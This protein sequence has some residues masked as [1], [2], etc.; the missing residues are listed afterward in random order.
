M[1]AVRILAIPPQPIPYALRFLAFLLLAG[2]LVRAGFHYA[3][4]DGAAQVGSDVVLKAYLLGLRYDLRLGLLFLLPV[5]VLAA[6]P[7][8]TPFG[9]GRWR[10]RLWTRSN[11]GPPW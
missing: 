3:F 4:S 6:V 2:L 1:A 7:R 8:L 5:L 11:A 9:P 10:A